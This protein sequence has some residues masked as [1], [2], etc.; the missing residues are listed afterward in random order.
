[1]PRCGIK[2][3]TQTRTLSHFSGFYSILSILFLSPAGVIYFL[4]LDLLEALFTVYL[5]FQAFCC[6][7]TSQ[8]VQSIEETYA[9]QM[10]LDSSTIMAGMKYVCPTLTD[11][12]AFRY[13]AESV[14]AL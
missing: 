12:S 6:C 10:L 13:D 11:Q 2:L 4:V 3:F 14:L 1:M 7:K 5:A 8:E 9:I